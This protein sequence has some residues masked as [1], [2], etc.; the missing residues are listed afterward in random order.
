V[1][2]LYAETAKVLQAPDVA[3]K[4]ARLGAEPMS[5]TPAQFNSYLQREIR[6]NAEL[7]KKAGIKL[8]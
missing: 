8:E 6:A 4:L 2:R 7:V 1:L 3:E 5:Y